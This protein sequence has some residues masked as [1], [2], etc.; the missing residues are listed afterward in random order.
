MGKK[1]E[2][3]YRII[4]GTYHK[5]NTGAISKRVKDVQEV[6]GLTCKINDSRTLQNY[7]NVYIDRVFDKDVA[8][9]IVTL[10]K[11][12]KYLSYMEEVR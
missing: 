6:T 7:Y 9:C 12:S 4:V 11:M 8:L 2:P 10:L 1:K 5:S 3:L